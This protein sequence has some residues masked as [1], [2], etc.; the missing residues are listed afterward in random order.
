MK[1]I[2]ENWRRSLKENLSYFGNA[3]VEFKNR[4][5]SGEDA[6]TVADEILYPLGEGSTRVVFGFPDNLD[7]VLKVINTRNPELD[8]GEDK[9]GFNRK[10][11]TVS[12]ENEV[13]FQIHQEYPGLFP[14]GYER[15]KDYSWIVTE[16]VDPMDHQEMLQLF[17]LPPLVNK[18]AYKKLAG[19]AVRHF[20]KD[21]GIEES[22]RG[23][24]SFN[25]LPPQGGPAEPSRTLA[26]QGEAPQRQPEVTP[27]PKSTNPYARENLLNILTTNL[28][29]RKVFRAA[30]ELK[31]P[32]EEM[33]AK[34]L[35]TV[36]R[37][38]K[39][40]VVILDASLWEDR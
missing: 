6:L 3:F 7:I 13:D 39:Q 18:R 21:L 40:E 28:Q 30:A 35:G 9:Y 10:H 16:R 25:T 20:K 2:F 27:I 4:V 5:D 1:L 12:N 37:G 17:G 32:A 33:T 36:N 11:K 15:A 23:K 19:H 8:G 31:I 29:S 38:G 26:P 22:S 24:D 34:N 14:K